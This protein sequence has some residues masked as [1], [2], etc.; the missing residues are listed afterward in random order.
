MIHSAFTSCALSSIIVFSI[1]S[2]NLYP[3]ILFNGFSFC[4]FHIWYSFLGKERTNGSFPSYGVIDRSLQ[5]IPA[6]V[7]LCSRLKDRI[8]VPP[9]LFASAMI[10]RILVDNIFFC[11]Q[12]VSPIITC[13][14]AI[15][16]IFAM[17]ILPI[18]AVV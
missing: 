8:S 1:E 4:R 2:D 16:K 17:A 12:Y 11:F 5:G 10:N 18:I 7:K 15:L 6:S 9:R 13:N 3:N 14:F